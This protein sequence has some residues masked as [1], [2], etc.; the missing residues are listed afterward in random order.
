VKG[1]AFGGFLVAY[2]SIVVSQPRTTVLLESIRN[3][4]VL[5]AH[6]GL[7]QINSSATSAKVTVA[8]KDTVLGTASTWDAIKLDA[9]YSSLVLQDG[10]FAGGSYGGYSE[11]SVVWITASTASVRV[12]GA[13][14]GAPSSAAYVLHNPSTGQEIDIDVEKATINGLIH[15]DSSLATLAV[16][17]SSFALASGATGISFSGKTAIVTNTS[18]VGGKDQISASAGQVTVR[19]S[20]FSTYE[21][22]GINVSGTAQLD[23]GTATDSGG[24]EFTGSKASGIYGLYDSRLAVGPTITVSGTSF[25]GVI[26]PAGVVTK[27]TVLAAC[28]PGAYC[29]NTNGNSITFF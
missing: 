3:T 6:S 21:S 16:A 19:T 15:L 23:L 9:P 1:I 10:T 5:A 8:G 29:I 25:N 18:F 24:N 2:G 12:Q 22:H 7:L 28:E 4:D 26:P 27:S 11:H 13:T 14:L 20:K 17:D